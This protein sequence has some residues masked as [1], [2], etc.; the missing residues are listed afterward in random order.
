MIR[1]IIIFVLLFILLALQ[2][3]FINNL[4]FGSFGNLILLYTVTTVILGTFEE[5][6]FT[7]LV[8][9]L[10]LDLVSGTR[11]G[12]SI[13][14]LFAV[15]GFTTLLVTRFTQKEPNRWILFLCVSAGTIIFNATFA[16]L[17]QL[18]AVMHLANVLGFDFALGKKLLLDLVVNLVLAYPFLYIYNF[19]QNLGSRLERV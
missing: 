5:S 14:S 11:A 18:L 8:G 2:G 12:L 13:V 9:G 6:F 15:F 3:G 19:S 1:Y 17:S 4:G 10:M 16:G 7:V